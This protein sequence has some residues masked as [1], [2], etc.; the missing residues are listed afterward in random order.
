MAELNTVEDIYEFVANALA[1]AVDEP[2]KEIRL[3][4]EMWH[5]STGFTGDYTRD[6]EERGV[7]D[8]KVSKLGYGVAKAFEK[9]QS[10]MQSNAHEPWNRAT[11]RLAPDGDFS[12]KFAYD[13][14]LAARL[15]AAHARARQQ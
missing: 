11:F 1:S 4:T 15:E 13:A 3:H 10:I 2:W 12:V 5:T 14:E 9:L 6:P 7:A 8:L